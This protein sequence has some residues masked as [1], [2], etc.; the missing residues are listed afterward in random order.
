MNIEA[1][2]PGMWASSGEM[3]ATAHLLQ[4]RI[5]CFAANPESGANEWSWY[6][7]QN[8]YLDTPIILLYNIN[9][10]HFMLV[11]RVKTNILIS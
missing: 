4:S 7:S 1:D 9:K 8:H 10:D 2:K 5:G 6:P 11:Q 3:H